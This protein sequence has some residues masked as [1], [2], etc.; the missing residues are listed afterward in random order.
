MK[1]VTKVN[2]KTVVAATDAK[3]VKALKEASAKAVKQLV[4]VEKSKLT[5]LTA[6]DIIPKPRIASNK[7]K[8]KKDKKPG[9]FAEILNCVK[10]SDEVG[11]NFEDILTHLMEKFPERNPKSMY[12]TMR[13]QLGGKKRPLR[14]EKE[15]KI[16]LSITQDKEGY[17]FYKI[18]ELTP[19][20]V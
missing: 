3:A 9:V 12:S 7:P 16:E 4:E 8:I 2:S 6:S 15:Q 14:F 20:T 10:S 19:A 5:K 1:K 17:K 18:A 13:S 11:V